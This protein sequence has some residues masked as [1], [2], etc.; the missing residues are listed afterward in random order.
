MLI[1]EDIYKK[2]LEIEPKIEIL[3][4]Y[5]K[6]KFPFLFLNYSKIPKKA[7]KAI[8][9][10]NKELLVGKINYQ[11]TKEKQYILEYLRY[12]SYIQTNFKIYP[13]PLEGNGSTTEER[14]IIAVNIIQ[15]TQA[16]LIKPYLSEYQLEKIYSSPE[17]I[18]RE[19]SDVIIKSTNIPVF[20][21]TQ[22]LKKDPLGN[23][24]SK[25]TVEEE[26]QKFNIRTFLTSINTV[27]LFNKNLHIKLSDTSLYYNKHKTQLNV[28]CNIVSEFLIFNYTKQIYKNLSNN[29]NIQSLRHSM[30]THY[31]ESIQN[32]LQKKSYDQNI[33][34]FELLFKLVRDEINK[35]NSIKPNHKQYIYE[36]ILDVALKLLLKEEILP[37]NFYFLEFRE[38]EDIEKISSEITH[39]VDIYNLE[40]SKDLYETFVISY[41]EYTKSQIYYVVSGQIDIPFTYKQIV[42][43]STDLTTLDRIKI[44]L[45][46]RIRHLKYGKNLFTLSSKEYKY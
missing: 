34:N 7:A 44:L 4:A 36:N 45:S 3:E 25:L 16:L 13:T 30:K 27:D 29:Q 8:L 22:E 18:I 39:C 37:N 10:Y 14:L 43:A 11:D 46:N 28:L 41:P 6:A 20:P 35:I 31:L 2:L 19:N 23:F 33:I 24:S 17:R 1:T 42:D 38:A 32:L 21:L 26:N 15:E 12:A 5:L 40:D 9:E